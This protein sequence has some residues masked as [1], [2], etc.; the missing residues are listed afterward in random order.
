[1]CRL[2]VYRLFLHITYLSDTHQ[3]D[4]KSI[5]IGFLIRL[6][7]E[8]HK[9]IFNCPNERTPTKRVWHLWNK[10]IR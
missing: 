1:M 6:K 9:S 3:P 2:N 10:T 4:G 5:K 8:F 7:P